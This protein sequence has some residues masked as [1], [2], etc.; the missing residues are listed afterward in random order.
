MNDQRLLTRAW[1][2][3]EKRIERSVDGV[4]LLPWR[5]HDLW[6]ALSAVAPDFASYCRLNSHLAD[7][8]Q[9]LFGVIGLVDLAK[10]PNHQLRHVFQQAIEANDHRP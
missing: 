10:L 6:S 1:D 3:I 7:C 5:P 2:L 9:S 8:A 4:G